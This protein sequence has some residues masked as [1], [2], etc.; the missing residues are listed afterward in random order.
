MTRADKLGLPDRHDEECGRLLPYSSPLHRALDPDCKRCRGLIELL[1]QARDRRI[2]AAEDIKR[3][4]ISKLD[5][6]P[7]RARGYTQTELANEVIEGPEMGKRLKLQ[8]PI[9]E[10]MEDRLIQEHVVSG[11]QRYVLYGR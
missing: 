8:R 3:K 7:H 1:D 2:A 9:R 10:L 5:G 4:I 6:L 11:V